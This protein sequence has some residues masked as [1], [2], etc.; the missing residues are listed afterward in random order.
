MFTPRAQVPD[1]FPRSRNMPRHW[2]GLASTTYVSSWRSVLQL[3]RSP[4]GVHS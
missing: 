2:G 1:A 3:A 4:F